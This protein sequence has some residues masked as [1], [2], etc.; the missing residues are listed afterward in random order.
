MDLFGLEVLEGPGTIL[1]ARNTRQYIEWFYNEYTGPREGIRGQVVNV[2]AI[3]RTTGQ[4]EGIGVERKRN[5]VRNRKKIYFGG[6]GKYISSDEGTTAE[7]GAAHWEVM[8]SPSEQRFGEFHSAS[9][10]QY[11]DRRLQI[12]GELCFGAFIGVQ[13]TI[14]MAY[15]LRD[16]S[17]TLEE[18][19][20]EPFSTSEYRDIYLNDWLQAEDP[21]G[22]FDSVRCTGQP[23]PLTAAPTASPTFISE[24]SATPSAIASSEVPVSKAAAI[25]LF[26]AKHF[27]FESSS[28]NSHTSFSCRSYL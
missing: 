1:F 20:S 25:S 11:D 16:P 24:P 14:E 15:S 12:L 13:Y 6:S 8:S 21:I 5:F 18:I 7:E 19:T 22:A 23:I 28:F 3:I 4:V 10:G 17:I 26:P 2:R 27:V 9:N